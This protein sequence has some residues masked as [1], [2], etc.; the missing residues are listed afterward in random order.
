M[1][2]RVDCG[3]LRNATSLQKMESKYFIDPYE[4]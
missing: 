3:V 1:V 4:L 2:M